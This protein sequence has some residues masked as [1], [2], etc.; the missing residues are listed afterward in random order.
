MGITDE[1]LVAYFS[2]FKPVRDVTLI[3]SKSGIATGESS[4]NPHRRKEGEQSKTTK[5]AMVKERVKGCII[6]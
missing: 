6:P 5:P 4:P 3:I 2:H 1:H